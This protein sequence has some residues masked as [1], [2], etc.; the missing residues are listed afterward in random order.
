MYPGHW[1]KVFPHKPA[2]V[3]ASSGESITYQQLDDRSNQLAQLMWQQGLRKG[4]HV[5]IF[6][7]NNLAFFEVILD[8]NMILFIFSRLTVILNNWER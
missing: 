3:H 2:V 8:L 1:S 4:D 5:S 7:E 6:M